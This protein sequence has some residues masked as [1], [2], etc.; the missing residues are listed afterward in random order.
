MLIR[1]VVSN[2]LSFGEEAEFNTLTGSPRRFKEHIYTFDGLEL[3][4]TAAIYGPNGAGKSN[5]VRAMLLLRELVLSGEGLEGFRAQPFRLRAELADQPTRLEVEFVIEGQAYSYGLDLL[6]GQVW[7]EWLYQTGVKKEELI[8]L[9]KTTNGQTNIEMGER[10]LQTP[11]DRLRVQLYEEELLPDSQLL[12]HLL[13]NAKKIFPEIQQVHGWFD[14]HLTIIDAGSKAPFLSGAFVLSPYFRAF[15]NDLLKTLHTGVYELDLETIDLDRYFGEDDREEAAQIRSR[16]MKDREEM[17]YIQEFQTPL[18]AVALWEGD[19]IVVKRLVTKHQNEKGELVRF[20]MTEESDGT[21]RILDFAPALYSIVQSP[22]T[23]IVD[24]IDQSIHPYLLKQLIAKFVG[25]PNTKGQL[26]F[27][28]HES[29]LLDQD[30][31]RQDEIWFAEKKPSGETALYPLSDFNIRFDL[32]IQKGYLNG[33][34]G[35]IPF[36]GNLKDLNWDVYAAEEQG[37]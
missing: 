11:E 34:F 21:L 6:A 16:L 37:V 20:E 33:R 14:E 28:T 31:F 36:L 8:F 35:A 1:F 12:L 30:I 17:E 13:A 5:L 3:L 25:N 24:E 15:A 9:R 18:W 27:T 2:Y 10:F 4:K 32:D 29:N 26:I 7:E 22:K 19:R 23:V